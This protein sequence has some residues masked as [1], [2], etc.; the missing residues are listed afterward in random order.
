[1]ANMPPR[2]AI[3]DVANGDIMQLGKHIILTD[4]PGDHEPIAR[5][6]FII[7]Y[8]IAYLGKPQYSIVPDLV[9]LDRGDALNDEAAWD[10]LLHK[11]NLHPRA[12][13]LGYRNDGVDEMMTVKTLDLAQPVRVFAF[14][15]EEHATPIAEV[16]VLITANPDAYPE[17]VR[18]H[19]PHYTSLTEWQAARGE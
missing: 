11:S 1:M 14:A 5:G 17:R 2:Q 19:L 4:S 3:A 12:D 10:F 13:V 9:V 8:G 16:N 15:K 7:R 6:K 18:E